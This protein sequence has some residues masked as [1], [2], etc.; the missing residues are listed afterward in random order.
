MKIGYTNRSS[1][2][3]RELLYELGCRYIV[4]RDHHLTEINSF[5]QFVRGNIQHEMVIVDLASIGTKF[6]INQLYPILTLIKNN[7]GSLI[8]NEFSKKNVFSNGMYIELLYKMATHDKQAYRIRADEA[9]KTAKKNGTA[10][11]RPTIDVDIIERIRYMYEKENMTIQE[12]AKACN[13]S[14]GTVYK[15]TRLA[16]RK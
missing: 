15:Y 9:S 7:K 5:E 14:I 3:E 12:V 4:E 13:V 8:I 11:G 1:N 6:T 2:N 10:S 16:Y